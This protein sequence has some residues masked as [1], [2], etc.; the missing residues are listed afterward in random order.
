[1]MVMTTM[2]ILIL[3]EVGHMDVVIIRE[4]VMVNNLVEIMVIDTK[5]VRNTVEDLIMTMAMMMKM[6]TK[7]IMEAMKKKSMVD[8]E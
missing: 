7:T 2:M 6:L 8:L 3:I 1:M 4:E 5:V